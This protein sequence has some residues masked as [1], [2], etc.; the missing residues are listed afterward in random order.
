M[1]NL[2]TA[3]KAALAAIDGADKDLRKISLSIHGKPELNFE[4]HHA[5][6]VLT[7]YLES[8]SLAR[9]QQPR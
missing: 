2:E 5:H 7:D 1:A 3:Q 6:K 8:R 9:H 4:E